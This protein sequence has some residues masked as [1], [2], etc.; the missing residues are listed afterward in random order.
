LVYVISDT[1]TTGGGNDGGNDGSNGGDVTINGQSINKYVSSEGGSRSMR[2]NRNTAGNQEKFIVAQAGNGT[3]SFKGN[4]GKYVSS[5][6]GNKA[7]N[8]NRNAVGAWE[9]FTLESLG[10]DLYAIKGNNGKYV[11]HENGNDK[12]IFCNRNAVGAWE[13]FVIKG[14]TANR[15]SIATK[16]NA[17][18]EIKVYPNPATKDE[19]QLKVNVAN[20]VQ[21]FVEIVDLNGKSIA[22]K[23]LGVLK[24]GTSAITMQ[25]ILTKINQSGLYLVRITLGEKTIV[26]QLMIK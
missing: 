9:K 5:E 7:M 4:N 14:L 26:K 16:I 11:S 24:A 6:N 17:P 23:D 15:N 21:S 8:C 25:D 20:D 12:G 3:V 1:D 2:A 13:K 22:T 19:I 10:G 18:Q